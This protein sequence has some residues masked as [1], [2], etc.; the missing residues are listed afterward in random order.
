MYSYCFALPVVKLAFRLEMLSP[1]VSP[2]FIGKQSHDV[3][4]SEGSPA[5]KFGI[6][7][8]SKPFETLLSKSSV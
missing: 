8:R 3:Q 7:P 5:T 6:E 2:L 4:E 1:D